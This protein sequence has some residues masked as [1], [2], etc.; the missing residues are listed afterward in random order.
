MFTLDYIRLY[1]VDSYEYAND[2][3]DIIIC[4]WVMELITNSCISD[5]NTHS[6][7]T[8]GSLEDMEQEVITFV[9]IASDEIFVRSYS[10]IL[11]LYKYLENFVRYGLSNTHGENITKITAQPVDVRERLCDTKGFHAKLHLMFEMYDQ[12]YCT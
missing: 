11:G 9:K 6:K 12:V 1:Q 2:N 3:E 10:I 7:A 8:F 5:L 4:E